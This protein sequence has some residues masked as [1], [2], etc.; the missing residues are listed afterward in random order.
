MLST[1]ARNLTSASF[2]YYQNTSIYYLSI[3]SSFCL[4][5]VEIISAKTE[6]YSLYKGANKLREKAERKNYV[7]IH[8]T[9]PRIPFPFK[10]RFQMDYNGILRLFRSVFKVV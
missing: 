10:N 5:V 6:A 7:L 8:T 1:I 4:N 2:S 3:Q 9:P